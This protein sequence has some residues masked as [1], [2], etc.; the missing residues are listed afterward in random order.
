MGTDQPVGGGMG[1]AVRCFPKKVFFSRTLSNVC[2]KVERLAGIVHVRTE[3]CIQKLSIAR[4]S[5]LSLLHTTATTTMTLKC[6]T[7]TSN[8]FCGNECRCSAIEY[9]DNDGNN[10]TEW[11]ISDDSKLY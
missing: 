3:E 8:G 7:G 11:V 1:G 10:N 5:E 6:F 4:K 9:E 2:N